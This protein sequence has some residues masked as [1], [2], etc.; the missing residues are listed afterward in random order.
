MNGKY[1]IEQA[2]EEIQLDANPVESSEENS[3]SLRQD[4]RA[5]IYIEAGGEAL[6]LGAILES[7][8]FVS[9]APVEPSTIAKILD[10]DTSMIEHGLQR[11]AQTYENDK[12][13]LRLQQRNGK[14]QLVTQPAVASIIEDFLNLDTSSK[15][16]GPALETLAVIAYRQ[17]ITRVQIEAVRGVDS[18]GVLRSLVQRGLVEEIGR[19]EVAGRPILYSVTD[20]FMQHFGLTKLGELPPL[21]TTEADTLWATTKLA[22]LEGYPNGKAPEYVSGFNENRSE[23]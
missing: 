13:G 3:V 21:E 9:D 14:F 19:L 10:F 18:A 20:S 2:A 8:L 6:P 12:R 15:L 22:E 4:E 11:L 17:P 1:R 16:S 5:E 23:L 7:L